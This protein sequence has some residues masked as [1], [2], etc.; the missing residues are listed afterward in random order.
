MRAV[1]SIKITI[2][3]IMCIFV[4]LV[5]GYLAYLATTPKL[6]ITAPVLSLLRNWDVSKLSCLMFWPAHLCDVLWAFSFTFAVSATLKK[7]KFNYCISFVVVVFFGICFE[8][9]QY[10]NV[11]PGTFD[12]YDI[13]CEVIAVFTATVLVYLL[14]KYLLIMEKAGFLTSETGKIKIGI[15]GELGSNCEEAAVKLAEKYDIKNYKIIPLV[16]SANVAASLNAEYIDY[17]VMATENSIAGRVAET[18]LAMRELRTPYH[19]SLPL[20]IPIHHCIFLKP[21]V[22]TEDLNTIVS[23]IQALKQTRHTRDKLCPGLK[24]IKAED[25]AAAARKLSEGIYPDNYAVI[26]RKNAGEMYGLELW[27]ENIEDDKSNETA[28]VMLELE[29]RP[30]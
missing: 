25:T 20:Y 3:Y 18:E 2:I 29:E 15:Q 21:D 5:Y 7:N 13:L 17:G 23:H 1:S 28:F 4:P 22:K 26:C 24:E 8:V 11:I 6:P 12:I 27:L 14:I 19:I 10:F 30:K 16:T 9:L